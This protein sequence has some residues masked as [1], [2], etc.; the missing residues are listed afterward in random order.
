ML[1]VT[2]RTPAYMAHI[3]KPSSHWP[4]SSKSKRCMLC[5]L[6]A[7]VCATAYTCSKVAVKAFAD[8]LRLETLDSGIKVHVALPG[9]VETP[10]LHCTDI[11]SLRS[12]A[13]PSHVLF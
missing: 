12:R 11:A 9:N 1:V 3:R 5:P 8:I 6:V 7:M 13:S 10:I 2:S 4:I